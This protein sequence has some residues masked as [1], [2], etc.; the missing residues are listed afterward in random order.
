MSSAEWP[1]MILKLNDMAS[2][3]VHTKKKKHQKR[4]TWH[5]YM[6]L[7]FKLHESWEVRKREKLLWECLPKIKFL[8]PRMPYFL[9]WLSIYI[10]QFQ[11]LLRASFHINILSFLNLYNHSN[12]AKLQYNYYKSIVNN[13]KLLS[14][15]DVKKIPC[16]K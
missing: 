15:V 6:W 16:L 11:H 13:I 5:E 3:H 12:F 2:W 1:S 14:L 10:L 7:Q 9:G 4:I 8:L